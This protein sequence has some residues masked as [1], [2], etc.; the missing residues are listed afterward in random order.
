MNVMILCSVDAF[1]RTGGSPC[2]LTVQLRVDELEGRGLPHDFLWL[3]AFPLCTRGIKKQP[4]LI[5]RTDLDKSYFM[6]CREFSSASCSL[7]LST[8]R[9]GDNTWRKAPWTW[10]CSWGGSMKFSFGWSLRCA[11]APSWAREYSCL[12]SLSRLLPSMW[13]SFQCLVC[14][15]VSRLSNSPVVFSVKAVR[16]T[17]T[18]TP[19]LPSLWGWV[20]RPLADWVRPGRCVP[21]HSLF[22]KLLT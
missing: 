19:S 1:T 12:R 20:T 2:R 18:W 3:G 15:S 13:P 7:S 10:T 14:S 11:C 5:S 4:G 16:S 6:Y 8:T 9:L 17:G 21:L 22:G